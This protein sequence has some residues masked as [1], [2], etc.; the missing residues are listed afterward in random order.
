VSLFLLKESQT[1]KTA[2]AIARAFGYK[3]ARRYLI[4]KH[5][6]RVA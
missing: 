3:T 6:E 4:I 1:A 2:A 5:Q